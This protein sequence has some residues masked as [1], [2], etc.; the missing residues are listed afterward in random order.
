[1]ISMSAVRCTAERMDVTCLLRG[2]SQRFQAFQMI[3]PNRPSFFTVS[4]A[5]RYT[6]RR[7][8]P[9]VSPDRI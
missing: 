7:K 4:F 1:M 2:P 5:Y 8:F 3:S 6:H 9:F